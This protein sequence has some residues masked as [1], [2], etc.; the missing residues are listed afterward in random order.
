MASKPIPVPDIIV[1]EKLPDERL[2][3]PPVRPP[4]PENGGAVGDMQSYPVLTEQV[5]AGIMP[6][7]TGPATAGPIGGTSPLGL[8]ADSAIREVLSWRTKADDPKGFVAALNQ[9]FDLKEVEGHTEW[10]WT[11][12]SYT[13]Q[14]DMGAVTGAQ[15]SIYTRAKVAL[16]QSL[17]LLDGL[18]PLAPNVEPEDLATVQAVVRTQFTA[19]VNEFGVLG[20]PRVPRVDEL[21]TLLLGHDHPDAARPVPE[22][23]NIGGSLGLVKQ[24]FGLERSFVTTVAD[25]QEPHQLS[26]SCGLC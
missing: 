13:V 19:L 10:S 11:P 16:D 14:T 25:E 7:T 1:D 8:K 12:R 22:E 15:A 6:T 23:A 9:A 17:P 18:Y 5:P 20:G 24:R 4:A 2:P 3:G 21:F 26:D